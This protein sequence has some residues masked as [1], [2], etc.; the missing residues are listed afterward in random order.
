MTDVRLS[1]LIQALALATMFLERAE[2]LD[3]VVPEAFVVELR[4]VIERLH[5]E[6][7]LAS[8]AEHADRLED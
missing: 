8:E 1:R 6:L 2:L 4:E 3:D 5:E 7:D